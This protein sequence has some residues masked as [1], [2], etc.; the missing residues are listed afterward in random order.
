ME[1]LQFAV[2]RAF[3]PTLTVLSPSAKSPTEGTVSKQVQHR[4]LEKL[5]SSFSLAAATP[6]S[7]T[8]TVAANNLSRDAQLLLTFIDPSNKK[9]FVEQFPIAWKVIYF[10]KG[11][12]N[13]V[14]LTYTAQLAVFGAT[15]GQGNLVTPTTWSDV[16]MGDNW[17]IDFT[18][19]TYQLKLVS[20]ADPNQPTTITNVQNVS[21]GLL[22]L[23]CGFDDKDN[24]N[25]VIVSAVGATNFF[26]FD[27]HPVLQAYVTSQYTETQMISSNVVSPLLWSQ[28]LTGVMNGSVLT[29][30]ENPNGSYTLK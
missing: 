16:T 30:T 24:L 7:V 8:F 1:A 18:N 22:N 20:G 13:T 26:Q 27:F 21:K 4:R 9:L 6:F 23:G 11:N 2:N 25:P 14:R 15:I 19:N 3:H 29:L 17:S 5:P 12:H 10:A 28:D